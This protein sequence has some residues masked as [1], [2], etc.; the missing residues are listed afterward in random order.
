MLFE[1]ARG[2]ADIMGGLLGAQIAGVLDDIGHGACPRIGVRTARGW[3]KRLIRCGLE[4]RPCAGRGDH[5]R[6]RARRGDRKS[7]LKGKSV[8]VRVD[9]GGRRIIKTK[10]KTTASTG[11]QRTQA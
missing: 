6:R 9:L 4:V 7:V 10:K 11:K 8:S 5:R 2:E 1:R 3:G